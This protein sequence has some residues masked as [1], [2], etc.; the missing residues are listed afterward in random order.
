MGSGLSE[1][2]RRAKEVQQ[3]ISKLQ[4]EMA[5]V[6]V[7]ASAGGGMVKVIANGKGEVLAISIEKEVIDPNE[8]EM[9][10]DLIVAAVNEAVRKAHGALAE[11]MAKIT[12]GISLPGLF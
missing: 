11:E 6:T 9:L 8:Q 10:Q 1:I 7:E 5:N 2:M 3:K 12:G 4:E